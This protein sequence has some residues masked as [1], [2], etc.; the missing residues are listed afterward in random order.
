M[1]TTKLLAL[2]FLLAACQQDQGASKFQAPGGA[3]KGGTAAPPSGDLESRVRRL[4][5]EATKNS[6]ALAFLN[7]VYAQQKQQEQ[8]Q[9]AEE[10]RS[11]PAPDAVFAVG[12]DG[13]SFD[14]PA[15]APIT[16]V[17]AWDF[18]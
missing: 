1:R 13:N 8:A 6:E 10:E 15:G 5:E 3:S 7:K 12:I 4:E 16:L 2:V 9:R 18:A 11:T 14:G 17:E